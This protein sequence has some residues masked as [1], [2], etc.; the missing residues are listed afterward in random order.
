MLHV[1]E[2][3]LNGPGGDMTGIF[4][5]AEEPYKPIVL[6]GQGPA[7]ARVTVEHYIAEGLDLVP[8][9]GALAAAVPAAVDA[10]FLLLRDHGTWKLDAVLEFAIGYARDG[11]PMLGR[12]GTTIAAV[13]ALFQ[14]HWPTSAEL[15][16]PGGRI[17]AEG[18]LVQN[19]AYA[20]TLERLIEAGARLP[21]ARPELRRPGASGARASSPAPW[22]I[23]FTS[24]TGILRE[25]ITAGCW[26]WRIWRASRLGTRPPPPWSSA[27]TPSPKTGPWRRGPTGAE[28][29]PPVRTLRNATWIRPR[30]GGVHH[31]GGAEARARGPGRYY[32]DT[33]GP[34]S[35][36]CQRNTGLPPGAEH[37]S[38]VPRFPAGR[39]ARPGA[40]LSAA[41]HQLDAQAPR[42]MRSCAGTRGR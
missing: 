21:P 41:A 6:M 26:L 34:R 32:G 17:P 31:P 30:N 7:P 35:T 10:W 14:T 29:C 5:T 36:Y 16:M 3:H 33:D 4:V 12:V 38:G 13:A 25:W 15:W 39:R 11:H 24:R 1:V 37:G 18:E 20:G 23:R 27:S 2:P 9:S 28:P 22:W 19:P 40:L 8:G 42:S